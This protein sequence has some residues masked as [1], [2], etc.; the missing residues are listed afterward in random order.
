MSHLEMLGFS[1]QSKKIEYFKYFLNAT[2]NY[3]SLLVGLL[4]F[5]GRLLKI[6]ISAQYALFKNMKG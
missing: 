1:Q 4:R 2:L 3:T 6:L 5:D